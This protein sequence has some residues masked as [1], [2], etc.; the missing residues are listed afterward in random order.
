[1]TVAFLLACR[2]CCWAWSLLAKR[3]RTLFVISHRADFLHLGRSLLA[4]PVGDARDFFGARNASSN[5]GFIYSA[6]VSRRFWAAD[7]RRKLFEKTG[8]WNYGFYGVRGAGVIATLCPGASQNAS[9]RM[10]RD[11]PHPT[12][13]SPGGHYVYA[14]PHP[15]WKLNHRV[16]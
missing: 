3:R 6:R 10:K 13:P 11:S 15:E 9:S 14:C 2:C 5:Y 16:P 12:R 4:V 7:W 1:M 8:S